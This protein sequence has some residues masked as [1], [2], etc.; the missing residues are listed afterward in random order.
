MNDPQNDPDVYVVYV[1]TLTAT[2][3][4]ELVVYRDQDGDEHICDAEDWPRISP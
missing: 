1:R 2:D 4:S 3:G